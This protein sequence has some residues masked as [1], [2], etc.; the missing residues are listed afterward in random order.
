MLAVGTPGSSPPRSPLTGTGVLK[1]LRPS[2]DGLFLAEEA[3]EGHC[4]PGARRNWEGGVRR[5]KPPKRRL[6]G[7]GG[8]T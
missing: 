4:R 8:G 7:R 2:G 3:E 5:R 6:L 1:N